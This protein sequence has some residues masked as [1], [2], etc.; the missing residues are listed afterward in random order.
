MPP[1]ALVMDRYDDVAHTHTVLA[2]H[3]PAAD[4]ITLHPAAGHNQ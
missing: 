4:Q 1:V 3:D 2:A